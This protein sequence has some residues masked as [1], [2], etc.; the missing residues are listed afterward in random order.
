[1]AF[2]IG[3]EVEVE[4]LAAQIGEAEIR[5]LEMEIANIEWGVGERQKLKVFEGC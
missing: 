2:G 5:I 4:V 1:M 3:V